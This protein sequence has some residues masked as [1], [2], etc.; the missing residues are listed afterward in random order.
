[1]LKFAILLASLLA[2][3][4]TSIAQNTGNIHGT[5]TIKDGKPA[6]GATVSLV[7]S[8]DSATVKITASNRD[9]KYSFEQIPY[10]SYFIMATTTGYRK[11]L[12]KAFELNAQKSSVDLPAIPLTAIDR[13]M[14]GVTVTA[15]KPLIEQRIDRT[16]LNVDASITNMGASALEVLEKAPGVTVDRDGNISLKGK[17][18]VQVMVDGRLTQLSGPDLANLLRNMNSSQ[19]DQIEIMT[20]PP[21]RY[22]ASGTSGIINIKTK[23][24]LVAG[25]N[26]TINLTITQGRYPKTNE[27]LNFNYRNQKFNFFTTLA[28]NYRKSFGV[29][30][31]QRKLYDPVTSELAN[32]FDQRGDVRNQANSFNG[33]MGLDFFA[34]KKT[35]LGIVLN[36]NLSPSSSANINTNRILNATKNLES[37]TTARVNNEASWNIFS[38]NL[39]FRTLPGKKGAELTADIDFLRYHS[40]TDQFMI[41]AYHDAAG[42][43]LMAA[44]S[45][46][47]NLP[48]SIKVY[49]GRVDYSYNLNKNAKIEAGLKSG[50]VE[51]DNDARYDSIQNGIT[52][53]DVNRSNHFV[54]DE[55]INAAYLNY[56]TTLSKKW[57][58]QFGLRLENTNTRGVQLTTGDKFNRNYTQ[59][60]PTAYFQ[61][62]ANEKNTFAANFGRR[63]RR[64]NYSS[65]NPFIKFIDRYT[66]TRG[67][68]NLKP[69]LSNNFE[70]SHSWRNQ[71]TTTLNYTSTTDIIDEVIEQKGQEAYRMP[72]NIASMKQYGIAVSLNMP[73]AKW[74]SSNLNINAFHNRYEGVASGV[75]V[76]LSTNSYII[77]LLQQFRINKNLTGEITGR[78]RNGWLE[79]VMRAKAIWFMGAGLSQQV[80]KGQGT[81]RLTVKDIFYTQQFRGESRYGNVDF[82]FQQQQETRVVSLGFTYKFN[83]GKK[84]APV[85]RTKGSANEEQ[86]RIGE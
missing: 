2:L 28:H 11:Q 72:A 22:D 67:N 39:N 53:P 69:S 24:S 81:L 17:E 71:L 9:G 1:M 66:Y 43:E 37:I 73:F 55:N 78:F 20:N 6:E 21:A 70:I 83:K 12:I 47:G 19:L 48:Q 36:G 34:S 85:K 86:E 75:P 33:K 65:L 5:V 52:V 46:Q 40:L 30:E 42:N 4:F 3:A 44:D 77:N 80:M 49:S 32:H 15:K 60:F 56:S 25:Y 8:R 50:M 13:N 68:P 23:K 14:D 62:K 26:G 10:G 41:N 79:G 74:W 35:T 18:G 61:Y 54:Y 57:S 64:P 84:V 58:S 16:I 38:S 82:N 7:R 51:T 31:I 45:L 63:V 59:L 27:G 76:E 29:L